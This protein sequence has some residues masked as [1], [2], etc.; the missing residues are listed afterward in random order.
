MAEMDGPPKAVLGLAKPVL[1]GNEIAE[2]TF[3]FLQQ[4][5]YMWDPH[6]FH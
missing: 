2:D 5:N 4:T 1:E 3:K 6:L